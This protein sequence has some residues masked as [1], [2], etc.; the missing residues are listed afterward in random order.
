MNGSFFLYE[1]VNN[2]AE[3]IGEVRLLGTLNP[4]TNIFEGSIVD[5]AATNIEIGTFRGALYGPGR[6][7]LG[8]V[9]QFSRAQENGKI[10]VG[11]M[12]APRI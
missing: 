8:L 5:A 1:N 11:W 7:Q 9:F 10:Y 6:E 12:L 4:Q 2:A 3:F